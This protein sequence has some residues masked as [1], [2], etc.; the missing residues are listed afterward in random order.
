M[1]SF[2]SK[3]FII[4]LVVKICVILAKCDETVELAAKHKRA[5]IFPTNSGMGVTF[6]I[7]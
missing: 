5:L 2:I 4:I 7:N 1:C 6:Y 3:I